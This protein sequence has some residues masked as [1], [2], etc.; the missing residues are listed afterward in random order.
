M[1]KIAQFAWHKSEALF[2][3]FNADQNILIHFHA[4]MAPFKPERKKKVQSTIS[5][6]SYLSFEIRAG[7][8]D[9]KKKRE[10]YSETSS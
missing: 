1:K 5:D 10:V 4:S 3:G 9:N 2:A 7:A 6:G 8:N